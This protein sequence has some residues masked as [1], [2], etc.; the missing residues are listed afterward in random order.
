MHIQR[1]FKVWD[2]PHLRY[3]RS[4]GCFHIYSTCTLKTLV[5]NTRCNTGWQV[6][7]LTVGAQEKINKTGK[8]WLCTCMHRTYSRSPLPNQ[9]R[10]GRTFTVG[11]LH[12]VA[13]T[14]NL[15]ER[16][17]GCLKFSDHKSGTCAGFLRTPYILE[18]WLPEVD[19][20]QGFVSSPLLM[21]SLKCSVT[22]FLLSSERK[23]GSA[24]KG[25]C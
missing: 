13:D 3:S 11:V 24:D 20:I 7:M 22:W 6:F 5:I 18:Q 9:F 1:I 23:R 4:I 16:T 21:K 19:V 14:V 15:T 10:A 25:A 17:C 2:P 8:L 12:A